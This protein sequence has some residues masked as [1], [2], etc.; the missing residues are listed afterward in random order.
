MKTTQQLLTGAD[1][2]LAESVGRRE[3]STTVRLAPTPLE[4]DIGRRPAPQFGRIEVDRLSPDPN[5]PRSTF[6][7]EAIERLAASLKNAGQ[8]AP[9]RAR[10]SKAH[11]KWLIVA[12]ERRWRAAQHAGLDAVD[13]YF[14]SDPLEEN[15]IL[16]LQLVENLLRENLKPIEEALGFR[17]LME[18]QAYTGKQ[19]AAELSV[20]ESKVS[21]SLALL[22]LPSDIQQQIEAGDYA[23]RVAYEIAKL[24]CPATQRKLAKQAATGRSRRQGNLSFNSLQETRSSRATTRD[25]THLSARRGLDR[26]RNTSPPRELL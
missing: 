21:R 15:E 26:H 23:P 19:L 2:H 16:R 3:E 13:C 12:G 14:Y 6:D 9:I 18:Q 1:E 5:Q 20:P 25:S 22:R 17:R 24:S 4:S 8:L 7:A 11:K 10:W